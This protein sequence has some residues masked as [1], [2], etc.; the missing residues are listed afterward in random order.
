MCVCRTLFFSPFNN[1]FLPMEIGWLLMTMTTTTTVTVRE[2][3]TIFFICMFCNHQA[4]LCHF[5]SL[6][7]KQNLMCFF[8]LSLSSWFEM[9]IFTFFAFTRAILLLK[10]GKCNKLISV[11]S[12]LTYLLSLYHY[13]NWVVNQHWIIVLREYWKIFMYIF[14][15]V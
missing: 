3:I 9:E 15:L 7:I 6:V 12:P 13:S 11:L 5:G 2:S 1:L 8:A 4:P 10:W 14:R